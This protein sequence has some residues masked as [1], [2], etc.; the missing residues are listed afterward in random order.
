MT[1]ER[2]GAIAWALLILL[3]FAWYLVLAPPAA[4]SSWLAL[5]LTLPA[6]LLPLLAIG[7]GLKRA[8]F[9]VGV[10]ALFYFCHGVVA[11]WI[12]PS[13]RVPAII[14]A[15]LCVVAIGAIGWIGRRDKRRRAQWG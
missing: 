10:V 3:Q 6:L 11:A 5:A 9:W 13:A 12:L 8:L 4:G 14:E 1:A 7:T 15:L 2:I